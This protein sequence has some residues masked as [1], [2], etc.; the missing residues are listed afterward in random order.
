MI[1]YIGL[2]FGPPC[3]SSWFVANVGRWL[4]NGC[5]VERCLESKCRLIFPSKMTHV[6]RLKNERYR[7]MLVD[8]KVWIVV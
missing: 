4:E 6:A 7:P 3:I 1:L 2:L 5:I 8:P